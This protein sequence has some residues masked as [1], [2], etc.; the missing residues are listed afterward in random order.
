MAGSRSVMQAARRSAR[1]CPMKARCL[2]PKA[3]YR[4]IGRWEHEDVLDRHRA[5]M[6]GADELMRRR[7]GHRRASLWHAQMPC[8]LSALPGPRLQQGSR[9]MEPDGALL[10]L[11]PRAQHPGLRRF[12][13]A[14]A[15]ALF[16][17]K[18]VLVAVMDALRRAMEPL[19]AQNRLHPP[20]PNGL[21]LL[22]QGSCP[23]ST[24]KSGQRYCEHPPTDPAT[25]CLHTR[26][27]DPP[28]GAVRSFGRSRG[29]STCHQP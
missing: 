16:S 13:A 1:A 12:I 20:L 28:S 9:R 6:Q 8:R 19:T 18:N 5:R 3:S 4:T 29:D 7:S 22:M 10:Q 27:K 2:S 17:R 15:K 11:H 14:V 24:G 26:G 25:G 21:A 23:V